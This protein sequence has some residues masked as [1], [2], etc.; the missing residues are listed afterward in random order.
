M[1]VRRCGA[2]SLGAAARRS[3]SPASPLNP[4]S[5]VVAHDMDM[6]RPKPPTARAP[7]TT[8]T[9]RAPPL[10]LSLPASCACHSH[11]TSHATHTSRPP[12]ICNRS[13]TPC[14]GAVVK[15]LDPCPLLVIFSPCNSSKQRAWSVL[16]LAGMQRPNRRRGLRVLGQAVPPTCSSSRRDPSV[17][18]RRQANPA[19]VHQCFADASLIIVLSGFLH[20]DRQ[21]SLPQRAHSTSDRQGNARQPQHSR[22]HHP[23]EK[24]LDLHFF[25]PPSLLP[26]QVHG[27]P[28]LGWTGVCVTDLEAVQG[29][30]VLF[31]V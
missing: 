11:T 23:D 20:A 6:G 12:A 4:P 3:F 17:S 8:H 19:V 28:P 14:G 22:T 2:T 21:A 9:H 18:H 7:S 30:L 16:S 15:R 10:D 5:G 24:A 1:G 27:L 13:A 29:C 26:S 25:F 31:V